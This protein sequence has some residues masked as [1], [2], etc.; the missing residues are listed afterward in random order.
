MICVPVHKKTVEQIFEIL[1]LKFLANVLK[2]Q[3]FG[4][5]VSG[6]A[7]MKLSRL[8]GLQLVI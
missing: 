1:I 2:F 5:F 3:L 6:T 4:F 7:A 8:I